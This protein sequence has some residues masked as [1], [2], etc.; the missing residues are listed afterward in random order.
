MLITL[1][2]SDRDFRVSV[3]S[4]KGQRNGVRRKKRHAFTIAPCIGSRLTVRRE[5]KQDAYRYSDFF[6]C[7]QLLHGTLEVHT[8][9]QSK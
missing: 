5:W 9:F 4:T 2:Y 3:Y 1:Q 6:S 7:A 8:F